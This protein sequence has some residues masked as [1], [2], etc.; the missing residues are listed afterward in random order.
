MSVSV[1][2]MP[3]GSPFGSA[4]QASFNRIGNFSM[5]SS[6]IPIYYII[7]GYYTSVT[8]LT[9]TSIHGQLCCI[10][11]AQISSQLYEDG[12]DHSTN[13]SLTARTIINLSSENFVISFYVIFFRKAHLPLFAPIKKEALPA[14]L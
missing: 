2:I 13:N 3:I 14:T 11:A 5:T 6:R 12:H 10:P 7:C 4:I 1:F 9:M 8:C